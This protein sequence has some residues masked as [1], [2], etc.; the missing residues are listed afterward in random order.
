MVDATES[1][2]DMDYPFDQLA[3]Y[4][5]NAGLL[6]QGIVGRVDFTAADGTSLD[7]FN[8]IDT[9]G[10]TDFGDDDFL[11]RAATGWI[12]TDIL[13]NGPSADATTVPFIAP[14]FGGWG[15]STAAPWPTVASGIIEEWALMD[16]VGDGDLNDFVAQHTAPNSV[17]N[18][19]FDRVVLVHEDAA[20]TTLTIC[21]E[22]S[23]MVQQDQGFN[24]F[25]RYSLPPNYNE[26][27]ELIDPVVAETC[28]N[29]AA[30]DIFHAAGVK[31]SADGPAL[32]LTATGVSVTV[33]GG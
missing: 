19:F 30:G 17:V 20:G 21:G 31:D 2:W 13:G 14:D 24:R 10:D 6:G 23:V 33:A 27:D 18:P 29:A 15:N 7:D 4:S 22:M 5:Y 32:L 9:D 8:T 16:E 1:P 26:D 3:P 28:L 12:A 25:Y 11:P